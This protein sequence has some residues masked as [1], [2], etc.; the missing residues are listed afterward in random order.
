MVRIGSRKF[1]F[2][3]NKW[4][5]L[6][7]RMARDERGMESVEVALSIALIAAVAGFGMV[8]LGNSLKN[9]YTQAGSSFSPG[10][11]FPKQPTLP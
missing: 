3:R 1:S 10:S 5:R 2:G 6:L 7:V 11:S 8:F 9:W 4:G